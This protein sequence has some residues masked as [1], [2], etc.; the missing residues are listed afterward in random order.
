MT[1][2]GQGKGANPDQT[3]PKG[4]EHGHHCLLFYLHLL[5][6]LFYGRVPVSLF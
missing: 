5:E 6:A 1:Q 3:A 4:A 2:I